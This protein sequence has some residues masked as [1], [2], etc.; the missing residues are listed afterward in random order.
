M[1]D[2]LNQQHP[3]PLRFDEFAEIA[4]EANL[5]RFGV[6]AA[7]EELARAQSSL[8]SA[9][10]RYAQAA[11]RTEILRREIFEHEAVAA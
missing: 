1:S 8:R 4:N 2:S 10:V 9:E 7:R 3:V 5:A 11:Q 6:L